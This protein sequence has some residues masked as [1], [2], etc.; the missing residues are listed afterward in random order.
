MRED[1]ATAMLHIAR[2][3]L[4]NARK[5]AGASQVVVALA[6]VDGA[7]HME[8]RD[9]GSGFDATSPQAL[10]HR[11]LRNMRLRTQHLGGMFD[12]ESAPGLGTTLR[13]RMPDGA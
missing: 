5:H 10:N 11:G 6:D 13:V 8:I 12:L 3:A 1:R 4:S 9:D 7:L 2:E